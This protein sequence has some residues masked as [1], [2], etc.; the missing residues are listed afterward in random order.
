MRSTAEKKRSRR[1]KD[2]PAVG[3]NPKYDS[4]LDAGARVFLEQGFGAASMDAIA[5]RAG[6]SKATIYSHFTNK[7]ALFGEIVSCRCQ[8]TMPTIGAA[9][10]GDLPPGEALTQIGRQFLDMLLSPNALPLYRVVLSEAP[11][12]P[13]LGRIFY[14]SGPDRIAAAL[15]EYLARQTAAGTLDIADPRLAAE[16]FFG[17]VMGQVHLRVLLGI[18]AEPPPPAERKRVV[19]SAVGIFLSGTQHQAQKVRRR[20]SATPC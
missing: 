11:R 4:V 7:H 5:A 2:K 1:E 14:A 15:A 9:M 18:T 16:Q 13:E 3:A 6:V 10:L 8:E 17:M 12:F 20:P 19:A